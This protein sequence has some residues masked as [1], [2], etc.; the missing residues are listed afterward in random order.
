MQ[1]GFN[2]NVEV[3]KVRT[4]T[5]SKSTEIV[6]GYPN[7]IKIDLVPANELKHYEL[8][9]WLATLFAPIAVGFWTA[10]FTIPGY[11]SSVFW[12]AVIFTVVALL[13]IVIAF[14]YQRRIHQESI[15]KKASLDS[16]I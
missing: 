6:V 13:F 5:T 1:K 4:D 9:N 3:S 15:H 12:S 16:F 2:S 7:E 8:F 11:S 10:H 14:Y